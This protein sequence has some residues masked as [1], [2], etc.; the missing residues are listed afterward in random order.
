M[1]DTESVDCGRPA[2]ICGYCERCA[3][4]TLQKL[5]D[6]EKERTKIV[7][8]AKVAALLQQQLQVAIETFGTAKKHFTP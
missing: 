3:W 4:F 6:G 1:N 8:Q 7:A 2:L 5:R